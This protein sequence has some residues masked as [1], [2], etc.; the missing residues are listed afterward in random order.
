[1]T[2]VYFS[3]VVRGSPTGATG[4]FVCVD[5]LAKATVARVPV[6][7]GGRRGGRG[8]WATAT[9]VVGTTDAALIHFGPQLADPVNIP[10]Q[11]LRD[12]HE[13]FPGPDGS[14]WVASNRTDTAVCLDLMTGRATRYLSPRR[15]PPLDAE[16]PLQYQMTALET[17]AVVLRHDLLKRGH[18]LVVQGDYA[19]CCSTPNTAVAE[20]DLATGEVVRQLDVSALPEVQA[21]PQR[22]A[23]PKIAL[24]LFLRGLAMVGNDVYVGLSPA[25]ILH[26]DWAAGTVIDLYQHSEEVNVAVHGLAVVA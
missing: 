23:D 6:A 1:V 8:I 9:E 19:F 4:E 13:V 17:P 2:L 26:L 5:W 16:G 15:R 24:P 3:T 25:T 12:A 7:Q 20:F 22:V 18:N 10:T 14:L 21:L 11:E